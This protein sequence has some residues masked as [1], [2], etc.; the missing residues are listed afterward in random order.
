MVKQGEA[1]RCVIDLG[2]MDA[3]A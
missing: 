1:T 2:G 3:P